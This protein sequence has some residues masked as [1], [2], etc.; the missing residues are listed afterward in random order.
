[1]AI[2]KV[3]I[4]LS[5]FCQFRVRKIIN[6]YTFFYSFIEVAVFDFWFTDVGVEHVDG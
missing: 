6:I 2:N 5:K 1:M 3:S 4:F